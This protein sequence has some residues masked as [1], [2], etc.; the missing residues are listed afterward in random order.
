VLIAHGADFNATMLATVEPGIRARTWRCT[1]RQIRWAQLLPLDN[2]KLDTICAHFGIFRPRPQVALDDC[3]ALAN[4]L[5]QRIGTLER[6][7]TYMR[8]LLAEPAFA[9]RSAVAPQSAPVASPAAINPKVDTP[10]PWQPTT[11]SASDNRAS[12]SL[13]LTAV[14]AVAALV[15]LVGVEFLNIS[16]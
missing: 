10:I 12:A 11:S 8:A 14:V 7:G 1:L 5:F 16:W 4:I 3:L 13:I 2:Q 9:L 15:L 6:S